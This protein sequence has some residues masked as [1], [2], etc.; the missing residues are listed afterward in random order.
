MGGL[1][2]EQCGFK[3]VYINFNN[4]PSAGKKVIYNCYNAIH[5]GSTK[6][7]R[8]NTFNRWDCLLTL[9]RNLCLVSLRTSEVCQFLSAAQFC[10]SSIIDA[11]VVTWKHYWFL[12]LI[13]DMAFM[14]GGTQNIQY[15]VS[16]NEGTKG[17]HNSKLIDPVK[18]EKYLCDNLKPVAYLKFHL[19]QNL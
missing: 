12:R 8:S 17:E 13:T 1:F 19:Q 16:R 6:T 18:W 3:T 5:M 11:V 4:T 15:S 9:F 10:G 2:G 14:R 7:V